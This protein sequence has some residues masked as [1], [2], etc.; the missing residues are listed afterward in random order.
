MHGRK[1]T[2]Y[3][4][5]RKGFSH[6]LITDLQSTVLQGLCKFELNGIIATIPAFT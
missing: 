5:R 6:E 2:S 1:I 4:I 3:M